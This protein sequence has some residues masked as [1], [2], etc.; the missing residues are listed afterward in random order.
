MRREI[1]RVVSLR[2]DDA[3]GLE[4]IVLW[5]AGE[6]RIDGVARAFGLDIRR[7]SRL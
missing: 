5:T 1:E 3:I 6:V 4:A 7:R 2:G